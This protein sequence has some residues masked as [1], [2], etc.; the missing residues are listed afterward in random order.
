MQLTARRSILA[1]SRFS[2]FATLDFI[3]LNSVEAL[4]L[5]EAVFSSKD[6]TLS[7]SFLSFHFCQRRM[8]HAA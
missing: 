5:S 2:T 8:I 4:I 6:A 1:P 7:S 3:A